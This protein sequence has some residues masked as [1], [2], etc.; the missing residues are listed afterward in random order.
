MSLRDVVKSVGSNDSKSRDPSGGSVG[1]ESAPHPLVRHGSESSCPP[2]P[3]KETC[4][5]CENEVQEAAPTLSVE[6]LA[7]PPLPSNNH[8]WIESG[9]R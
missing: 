6:A 7:V 1:L 5:D 8:R 2:T 9:E 3:R 4:S